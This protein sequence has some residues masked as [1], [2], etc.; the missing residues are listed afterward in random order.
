MVPFEPAEPG[1]ARE[2]QSYVRHELRAP[3]AVLYPALSLLLSEGPGEL[4]PK[5]RE[6]LEVMERN[7]TRLAALIAGAADSGWMDCSAAPPEPSAFSL[8]TLVKET[9][10]LRRFGQ[11]WA[12]DV[13]LSVGPGDDPQA[14]ADCDDVRTIVVALLGNA[15]AYAGDGATVL[16]RLASRDDDTVALSVTDDGPGI[17]A[18][19]LT[20]A[21]EFGFRGA[22]A[23]ES[24]RP[25]LGIGL[26]VCRRLAE[27]NGGSLSLDTPAGGGLRATLLLPSSPPSV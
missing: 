18:Q 12:S 15:S 14:R 7:V 3:L 8:H 1:A 2:R 4:T 11:S 17:P 10:A 6:Y 22:A 19:E 24:A 23:Q 5:Q 26:W 27:R 20:R 25:G 16:V 9:I 13:R 21:G